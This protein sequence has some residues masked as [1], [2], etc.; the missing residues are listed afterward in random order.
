LSLKNKIYNRLGLAK[1]YLDRSQYNNAITIFDTS[2]GTLNVGD[3]IINDAASKHLR[4]IFPLHQFIKL[5]THD[6]ISNVGLNRSAIGEHRFIC[7]SNI[8]NSQQIYTQQWNFSLLDFARI[9]PMILMGVGWA[10][11]QKK[12]SY[13][14]SWLYNN[15]LEKNFFHSVRDSYTENMLK[16]IGVKKVLNTSCPTMWDLDEAHCRSIPKSKADNVIFTLT[17]YRENLEADAYLISQLKSLYKDVYIWIQGSKDLHYFNKFDVALRDNIHIVPPSLYAYDEILT[18]IQ[19]LD[20]VGTRLHAGIRALQRGKRTVIIGIDNRA[21]EKQ[22]DFNIPVV[23]RENISAEL[24][25]VLLSDF[26]TLIT[27]PQN[28][29]DLWKGQF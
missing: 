21:I 11:Y 4:K 22:K 27:L 14:T 3:E 6:G 19:S 5:T 24:R 16:K 23:L 7:G 8:L 26:D 9:E 28:N 12:P 18:S 29:I 1:Y 25:K 2:I 17:D 15:R 20:F 13:L 10:N